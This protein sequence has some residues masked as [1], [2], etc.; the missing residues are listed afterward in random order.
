MF[1]PALSVVAPVYNEAASVEEFHRR[2]DA[3][4]KGVPMDAEI[5]FV[6]DGSSDRSLDLLRT[7]R[8]R[9]RRIRILNFSR[10]FGHQAAVKAGIDHSRGKAVVTIDADLQDPPEA[11]AELVRMWKEGYDVVYAKRASRAGESLFKK[12]TAALYYRLLARISGVALPV[13]TGDFRLISRR[14]ADVIR[15]L[16]ETDPYLRGLVAWAGFKQ[17]AIEIQRQP[18]FAGRS[19]YSLGKMCALAWSGIANFSTLPLELAGWAGVALIAAGAV[20]WWTGGSHVMAAIA[21]VGGVQL[22]CLGVI[23]AYLGRTLGAARCRPLYILSE[24]DQ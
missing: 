23:G 12:W 10:N 2:L 15:G 24:D 20:T 21:L 16:R 11:I 17:T 14:V 22:L 18:R 19:S 6:N 8:A 7:L 3:A 4:L 13:D 5:L 9:D 1:E